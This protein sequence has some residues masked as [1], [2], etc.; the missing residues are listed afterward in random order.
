MATGIQSNRPV[1]RSHLLRLRA[2]WARQKKQIVFTNGVFDIL[3]VGHVELLNK[4]KSFGD[5]LV[6]GVNS[7]ASVRRLKGPSRPINSQRDRCNLLLAFSMVDHVC[8]F[9]EDTP[10]ELI[11]ALR[12]DVLVKGSEYSVA[13][14]VGAA[15]VRS[16]GGRVRRVKMKPGYSTTAIIR[17]AGI[18]N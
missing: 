17:R 10:L 11:Q 18:R 3:H 5:V 8:V 12:P 16:W 14:I 4:A 7:D 13:K 9:E 15:E 1:S 6:V 2:G